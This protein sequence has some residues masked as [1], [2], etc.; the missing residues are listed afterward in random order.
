MN[1]LDYFSHSTEIH[2]IAHN[3]TLVSSSQVSR[4]SHLLTPIATV[5]ESHAVGEIQSVNGAMCSLR[6]QQ[7]Y[8]SSVDAV[9]PLPFPQRDGSPTMG[10]NG[11]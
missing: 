10:A 7:F 4:V 5:Q 8:A 3:I 1:Y 2:Q 6:S 11:L 9:I